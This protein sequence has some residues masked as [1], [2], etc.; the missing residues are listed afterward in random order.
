[1]LP[2]VDVEMTRVMEKLWKK[3]E[4]TLPVAVDLTLEVLK[5]NRFELPDETRRRLNCYLRSNL[6]NSDYEIQ[7]KLI[8]LVNRR[9]RVTEREMTELKTMI[10]EME[11]M[12]SK[13]LLKEYRPKIRDTIEGAVI[14]LDQ[15]KEIGRGR[16]VFMDV[17]NTYGFQGSI[18]RNGRWE[19]RPAL[20]IILDPDT[21]Q[22]LLW[23]VH[24]MPEK[25]NQVEEKLRDLSKYRKITTWGK[26]TSLKND[27]LRDNIENVQWERNKNEVSLKDAAKH[28]GLNLLKLET[29]SNWSCET[30]RRDQKRYAGLDCLAVMKIVEKFPP[31]KQRKLILQN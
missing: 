2:K 9:G 26:E 18:N 28:V 3:Y 21:R 13:E 30:L 11:P 19:A 25:M 20:I 10:G 23:R 22:A 31:S 17:E 16:R 6:I 15:M 14:V 7:W 5:V 4:L 29:M 27:E 24:N 8:E 1:M 12:E